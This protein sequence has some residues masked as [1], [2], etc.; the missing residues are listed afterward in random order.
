MGSPFFSTRT[1]NGQ[2]IS[3]NDAD[4]IITKTPALKYPAVFLTTGRFSDVAKD[5]VIIYFLDDAGAGTVSLFTAQQLTSSSIK[6]IPFDDAMYKVS[7]FSST[8]END[9]FFGSSMI[10][11]DVDGN[12][13]NELIVAAPFAK[14][15]P[16][17]KGKK[18]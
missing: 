5:D 9:G 10:L 6:D 3:A 18:P 7:A 13:T 16:K 4:K 15:T 11:A 8:S 14:I 12:G 17:I 2:T 1:F